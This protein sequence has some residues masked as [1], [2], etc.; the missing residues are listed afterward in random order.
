MP[1]FRDP[2]CI[3]PGADPTSLRGCN[4]GGAD[5]ECRFCGFGEYA[6]CPTPGGMSLTI[7][8]QASSCPTVCDAAGNR[9]TPDAACLAVGSDGEPPAGCNAG[10]VGHACRFCGF[11]GH[12]ACPLEANASL[13]SPT[14]DSFRAAVVAEP[15]PGGWATDLYPKPY[16]APSNL[17]I[18]SHRCIRARDAVTGHT[19]SRASA[20][21]P[22]RPPRSSRRAAP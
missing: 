10:G 7:E 15:P 18:V 16:A 13:A 20:S 4:A 1:C 2:S 11:G 19:A 22:T 21:A 9:C 5:F 3:A 17:L 6:A 14:L 12:P 8:L